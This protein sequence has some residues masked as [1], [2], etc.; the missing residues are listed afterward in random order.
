M[1]VCVKET[2]PAEN[3]IYKGLDDDEAKF[4]NFVSERQ[5]EKEDAMYRQE[6]EE[7][8]EYREAV[9]KLKDEEES[10]RAVQSTAES[11]E[12]DSA[13]AAAAAATNQASATTGSKP[14]SGRGLVQEQK[15]GRMQHKSQLALIAG[16][17]KT[18]RKRLS[19]KPMESV[20]AVCDHY[21]R[22]FP[23]VRTTSREDSDSVG[24][25]SPEKKQKLDSVGQT[26]PAATSGA[27]TTLLAAYSSG[28]DSED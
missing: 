23:V 18:K 24:E 10:E 16:S 3:M 25:S 12:N 6:I 15:G 5:S 26:P 28:S 1:V 14:G 11:G 19:K 21:I 13:A 4:L 20:K 22:S 9:S 8:T 27:L 7:I 2:L 17:I